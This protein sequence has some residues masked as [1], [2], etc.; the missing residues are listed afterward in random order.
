[1]FCEKRHVYHYKIQVELVDHVANAIEE[2]MSVDQA[3]TFNMALLKVYREYS[4]AFEE[5]I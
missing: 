5:A 1:M 4:Q 2:K 3:A